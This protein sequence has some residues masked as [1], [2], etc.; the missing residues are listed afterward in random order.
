MTAAHSSLPQSLPAK[1]VEGGETRMDRIAL[2]V[3]A[4]TMSM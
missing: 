3:K 2:K 1:L 4:T